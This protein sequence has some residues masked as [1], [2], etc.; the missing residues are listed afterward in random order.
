M[1]VLQ[2]CVEGQQPAHGAA[3]YTSGFTVPPS[4]VLAVYERL[5]GF[6]YELDVSVGLTTAVASAIGSI[7]VLTVYAAVIYAD[8]N[9]LATQGLTVEGFGQLPITESSRVG[10]EEVLAVLHVQH[11]VALLA[12][13]V[14]AGQQDAD[15]ALAAQLR[16]MEVVMVECGHEFRVASLGLRGGIKLGWG[17]IVASGFCPQIKTRGTQVQKLGQGTL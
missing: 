9:G 5:E 10:R 4:A 16:D 8:H 1:A 11:G 14:V 3:H 15:A 13:E 12:A 7:F 2:P 17:E 6:C